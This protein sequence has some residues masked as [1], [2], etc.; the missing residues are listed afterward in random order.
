LE[1]FRKT[2]QSEIYEQGIELK[3]GKAGIFKVESALKL[4]FLCVVSMGIFV[5]VKLYQ[6]TTIINQNSS[7]QIPKLFI[8]LTIGL[9][10]FSFLSLVI[11][12]INFDQSELLRGSIALHVVSTV[13]DVVWIVMVRNRIN[14]IWGAQ[15][16]HNCW[17]HPLAVSI[18]HVIYIQYKINRHYSARAIL[19]PPRAARRDAIIRK[20]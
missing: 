14:V 11:A 16:D 4:L 12:L 20:C 7:N 15:R 17:L 6:L 13:F 10:S 19:Q 8:Y 5:I 3:T 18:F 2:I 1:C 9:F